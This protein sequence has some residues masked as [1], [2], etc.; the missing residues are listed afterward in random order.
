M[1]GEKKKLIDK[2]Y[3][4]YKI[5]LLRVDMLKTTTTTTTTTTNGGKITDK[6][7]A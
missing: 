1:K 6:I 4:R 5:E 2:V 7:V 3:V